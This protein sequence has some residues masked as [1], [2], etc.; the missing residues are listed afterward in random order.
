MAYWGSY[1]LLDFFL[2]HWRVE[3]QEHGDTAQVYQISI[4][5]EKMQTMARIL[6]QVYSARALR[7]ASRFYC[8]LWGAGDGRGVDSHVL[9]SPKP[10][11]IWS[12]KEAFQSSPMGTQVIGTLECS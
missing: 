4:A 3:G 10:G 8:R 5:D 1:L 7:W 9:C 11:S 2:L 12:P 6:T